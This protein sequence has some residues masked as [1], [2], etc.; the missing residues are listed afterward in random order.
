MPT[1]RFILLRL[2]QMLVVIIGTV[3]VL[4]LV[5]YLMVP[6]DAAQ[7]TLGNHATPESLDSLRHELGLDR[8]LWDQYGIYLSRLAHFDLGTS[9]ELKR[10]VSGVILDHLPATIYLTLAALFLETVFGVGWGIFLSLRRSSSLQAASAA[11][12]ALLLALPAFFLGLLLQYIFASQL[13]VL[14][15]SGIG[16]WNPL[17]LILPAVTLAAGQTAIIAAVS[18]SALA[19]EMGEPY[20]LAARARGLTRAQA[21]VRH[22]LRNSF[23]PVAT[24]LAIDLGTLLGGAMITEIVFSWPGMGRMTYFAAEQRDVPL[25]VGAVLVLVMIFVVL[26]TFVDLV[27]GWLD[28]RVRAAGRAQRA[29]RTQAAGQAQAAGSTGAAGDSLG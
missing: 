11:T 12:G 8:P 24:L 26:N 7:V 9:Y 23:G 28:P 25:V 29:G 2:L 16:G 19:G 6:G 22:G 1:T 27:Y 14:P 20:I 21:M 13:G 5:I 17:N 3:T 18:R 4:F 15:I 10:D